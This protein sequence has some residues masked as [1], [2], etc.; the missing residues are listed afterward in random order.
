VDEAVGYAEVWRAVYEDA[1]T[2]D[3]RRRLARRTAWRSVA[4]VAGGAWAELPRTAEVAAVNVVHRAQDPERPS[5]APPSPRVAPRDL[6]SRVFAFLNL[7][8]DADDLLYAEDTD[9][10]YLLWS[11]AR[12]LGVSVDAIADHVRDWWRDKVDDSRKPS[13]SFH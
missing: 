13:M 5:P 1:R 7:Q 10:P 6:R 12:A 3:V 8:A 2:A 9:D 4:E 11:T